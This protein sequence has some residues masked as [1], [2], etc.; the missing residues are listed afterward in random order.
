MKRCCGLRI[1]PLC[2]LDSLATPMKASTS[3]DCLN[4]LDHQKALPL[5]CQGRGDDCSASEG[6]TICST[7]RVDAKSESLSIHCV[8]ASLE[9]NERTPLL[10]LHASTLPLPIAN[11]SIDCHSIIQEIQEFSGDAGFACLYAPFFY[12]HPLAQHPFLSV[13]TDA[14]FW[15]IVSLEYPHTLLSTFLG[16]QL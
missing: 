9:P 12:V 14:T 8:T 2:L 11:Y 3:K 10:N 16:L 15:N 6:S 4:V 1:R 5:F 13:Y 7:T